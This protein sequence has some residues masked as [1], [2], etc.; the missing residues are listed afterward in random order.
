MGKYDMF[1]RL[2]SRKVRINPGITKILNK[3]I[4]MNPN[5]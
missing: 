1:L 5:L 4:I 3:C 2:E